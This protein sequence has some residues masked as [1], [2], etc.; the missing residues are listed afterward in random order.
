MQVGYRLGDRILDI[1][2]EM[3]KGLD[4]G[5]GKG[6]ASKNIMDVSKIIYYNLREDNTTVY[7]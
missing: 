4:L 6:Y 7:F 2:K 3:V 5:C 1:K